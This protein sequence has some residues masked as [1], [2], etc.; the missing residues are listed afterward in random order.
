MSDVSAAP[1]AQLVLPGSW[2]RIPVADEDASKRAIHNLADRVTKKI[3][4]FAQLRA[5][6]RRDL[7]LLA[8]EAREGGAG[9]LYLALEIVPG[10]PIPMSLAVFWPDLNVMGSLPSEP[11][12]V[13]D[14]VKV[15]LDSL[16]DAADYTDA[17]TAELGASVTYRRCKTIEHPADGETPA[18]STLLVDYWVAV[19]GTQHVALLSFSTTFPHQ[20]ERMLELFKVIVESL[21]WDAP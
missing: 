16:P 4:E 9:E 5:D 10:F 21:R 8:D 13:I 19:P 2:W 20:R 11:A 3:D 18:Y 1:S 12:S 6:L 15:A 7:T 14:I 17:E